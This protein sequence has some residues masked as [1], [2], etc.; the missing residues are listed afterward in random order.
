MIKDFHGN[1]LIAVEPQNKKDTFMASVCLLIYGSEC[2]SKRKHL[3]KKLLELFQKHLNEDNCYRFY[4]MQTFVKRLNAIDPE[5]YPESAEKLY[6]T[7]PKKLQKEGLAFVQ[8][9]KEGHIF[10]RFTFGYLVG[11]YF[12]INVVIHQPEPVILFRDWV[13]SSIHYNIHLL[14]DLET[15]C[16]SPLLPKILRVPYITPKHIIQKAHGKRFDL[17]TNEGRK[18]TPLFP[19]QVLGYQVHSARFKSSSSSSY[20]K[21]QGN[22]YLHMYVYLL[23]QENIECVGYANSKSKEPPCFCTFQKDVEYIVCVVCTE[24]EEDADHCVKMEKYSF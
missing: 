23:M 19:P 7:K 13:K 12:D 6:L 2:Q 5:K 15:H 21:I 20:Y 17:V 1:I 18:V 14:Y 3:R 22:G 24:K 8:K 9:S 16:F 10:D 11:E 4:C